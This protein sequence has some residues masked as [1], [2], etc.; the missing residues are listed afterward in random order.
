VDLSPKPLTGR[1][2]DRVAV[3]LARRVNWGGKVQILLVD[4]V[5]V[6]LDLAASGLYS[7][8]ILEWGGGGGYER[9][10][11]RGKTEAEG[12]EGKRR[13]WKQG[14]GRGELKSGKWKRRV[15]E[16]CSGKTGSGKAGKWKKMVECGNGRA[17][18]ICICVVEEGEWGGG[19]RGTVGQ[20]E[21]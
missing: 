18:R 1:P 16:P 15:G 6:D 3:S 14:R 13:K 21:G 2:P 9:L 20:R 11:A 10:G 5:R 4:K 12:V 17:G 8:S 19:L 7:L